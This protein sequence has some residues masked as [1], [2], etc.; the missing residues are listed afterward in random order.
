MPEA[1]N[2]AREIVLGSQLS[3]HTDAYSVS[4]ACATVFNRS[5]ILLKVLLVVRSMQA[6]PGGADSASVLPITLSKKL[7]AGMLDLSRARSMAAR[8]KIIKRLSLRD[9]K[10]T[11]PSVAEYL[12]G[13]RMG[14]TAE[15]MAKS[16][17]I[18]R[19]EQDEF[20]HRSHVRLRRGKMGC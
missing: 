14:D 4:R 15:Q 11:P 3:V 12:T 10:P 18:S 17:A 7:A 5:R 8:L 20:A 19:Q 1:P 9:L 6:S 2:I 13:L 16:Y